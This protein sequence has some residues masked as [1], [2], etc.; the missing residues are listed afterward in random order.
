LENGWTE[1]REG[2]LQFGVGID[3][4]GDGSGELLSKG[5]FHNLEEGAG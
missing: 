5:I 2:R 4:D 3:K 1:E